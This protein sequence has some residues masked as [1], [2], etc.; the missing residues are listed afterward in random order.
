MQQRKQT[1][2]E[3]IDEMRGQNI[4][5]HG[6]FVQTEYSFPRVHDPFIYITPTNVLCNEENKSLRVS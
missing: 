4:E 6:V 5:K 3:N 2:V 1:A